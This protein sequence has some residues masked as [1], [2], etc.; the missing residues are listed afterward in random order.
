MSYRDI[1]FPQLEIDEERRKKLYKDSVGKWSIGVGRNLEDNGLR[2]DEID[3]MLANDVN[4]AEKDA[5]ALIQN[6]DELSEERQA[7]V[8]NM[9]F[10]LGYIRLKKFRNTLRAINEGRFDD[11]AE[12]MKASVWYDQVGERAERLVEKMRHG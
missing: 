6:F 7:V 8:V 3:L 10:N 12:G 1:L 11:A 5:R 9:S 4:Q 2:D